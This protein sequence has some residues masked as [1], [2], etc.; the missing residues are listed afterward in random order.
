MEII[1]S[2]SG[3]QVI[4]SFDALAGFTQLQMAEKAKE[5]TIFR[6]HLDLWQFKCMPFSL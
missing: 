5:L 2:L 4:S 6:C 3:A 1:Q